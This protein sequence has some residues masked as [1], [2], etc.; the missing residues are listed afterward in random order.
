V[1]H[2]RHYRSYEIPEST[3]VV[4]IGQTASRSLGLDPALRTTLGGSDANVYNSKGLPCIVMAT[5][6]TDIHTHDEH[7]SRADLVLTAKL[8]LACLL[9]TAKDEYRKS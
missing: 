3:T 9:E 1:T 8:A 2:D 6:M 7:V 5:G 4:K